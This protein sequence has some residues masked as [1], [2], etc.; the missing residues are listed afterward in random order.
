MAEK[1][2]IEEITE[3]DLEKLSD[4]DLE[5]LE[6]DEEVEIPDTSEPSPEVSQEKPS[7]Q[8]NELEELKKKIEELE[9]AKDGILRDLQ[10]ERKKRQLY[11]QM[12]SQTQ[13]QQPSQKQIEE[14]NLEDE[15]LVTGR[16]AKEILK[17][18]QEQMERK[19]NEIIAQI[20][21]NQ[22]IQKIQSSV[23][24]AKEKYPDY[25]EKVNAFFNSL[26]PE[27]YSL[28]APKI[29]SQA[30]PAETCYQI[31]KKFSVLNQNTSINSQTNSQKPVILQSSKSSS[32]ALTPEKILQMTDKELEKL[33]EDEWQKFLK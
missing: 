17:K 10:E 20:E 15:E 24:R 13:I 2:R 33:S 25:D 21:F 31:A 3:A 32:G 6:R 18:A 11:E 4:E 7:T 22:T 19:I 27:E 5:K 30:D 1:K 28:L 29:L 14:F 16:Q 9:K 12:V 26:T 23:K 8:I